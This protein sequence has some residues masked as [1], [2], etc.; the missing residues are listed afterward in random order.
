MKKLLFVFALVAFTCLSLQQAQ[1]QCSPMDLEVTN[2][3]SCILEVSIGFGPGPCLI[4]G[5]LG[6]TMTPM[7]SVCFTIPSG[8]QAY[9]AHIVDPFVSWPA[10]YVVVYDPICGPNSDVFNPPACPASSTVTW[11]SSTSV[12]IN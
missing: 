8:H 5:Y 7:S 10:S 2:N 6:I 4:D 9:E 11:N 3:T 1:A 12:T